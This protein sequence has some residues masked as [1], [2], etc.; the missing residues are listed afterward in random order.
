MKNQSTT[1]SR[2]ETHI[3][4]YI[5]E[6]LISCEDRGLS[7]NSV[8]MYTHAMNR[9]TEYIQV[10]YIEDLDHHCIN[11]CIGKM[12]IQGLSMSSIR[13]FMTIYKC[14]ASWL[15][16]QEYANIRIALLES[17]KHTTHKRV[18][19]SDREV[20]NILNSF[21]ISTIEGLR[22]RAIVSFLATSG[23]RVSELCSLN[24]EDIPQEAL[25]KRVSRITVRG[26]GGKN[27]TIF[28]TMHTYNY[29][30]EYLHRCTEKNR[31]LFLS[32]NT[33]TMKWNRMSR[34]AIYNMVEKSWHTS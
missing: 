26:K 10:E 31:A 13:Y 8:L 1:R 28:L 23:L 22:D 19:L 2:R 18:I 11:S 33:K 21:D 17:V 32:K 7:Q 30:Q 15:N 20:K 6:Y 29:I 12:R 27:E 4:H 14:F 34:T 5:K 9:F 25:L 16:K 3:N 24:R